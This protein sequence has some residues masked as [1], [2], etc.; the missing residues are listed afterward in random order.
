MQP[1][2]QIWQRALAELQQMMTK[3]NYNAWLQHTRCVGMEG[4]VLTVGVPSTFHAEYLEK[5]VPHMIG[6]ALRVLGFD[7]LELRYAVL[8]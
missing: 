2:A 5:R 7:K 6:S 4:S 3:Q 8:A 1:G